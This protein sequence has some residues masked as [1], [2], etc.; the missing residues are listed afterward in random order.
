MKHL[1]SEFGPPEMLLDTTRRPLIPPEVNT[2]FVLWQGWNLKAFALAE[3]RTGDPRLPKGSQGYAGVMR[4]RGN[5]KNGNIRRLYAELS[6]D[7]TLVS[8]A[9]PAMYEEAKFI[10]ISKIRGRQPAGQTGSPE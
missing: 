3:F 10:R 2:I 9:Y 7:F 4:R 6:S 5:I 1:Q 8:R